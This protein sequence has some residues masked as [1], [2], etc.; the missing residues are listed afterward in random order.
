MPSVETVFPRKANLDF[1]SGTKKGAFVY[2]H[3]VGEQG[4]ANGFGRNETPPCFKCFSDA[5]RFLGLGFFGTLE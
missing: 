4:R 2:Y 5:G 3:G 1:K